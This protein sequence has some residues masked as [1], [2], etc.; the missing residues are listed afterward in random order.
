[1]ADDRKKR[2]G[3]DAVAAPNGVVVQ[4]LADDLA[5]AK[6]EFKA[7]RERLFTALR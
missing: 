2:E 3:G 4:G 6:A 1:M 5:A 7:N